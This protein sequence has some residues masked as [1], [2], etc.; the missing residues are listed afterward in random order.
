MGLVQ[1]VCAVYPIVNT[2]FNPLGKSAH[3]EQEHWFAAEVHPHEGQLKAYLHGTFPS[4]RDADDVVQESYL[5]LWKRQTIRPIGAA[6]AFLF[7]V[8]RHLALD[9]LR[10]ERR[11]PVAA[12][13]DLAA[14]FVIDDKPDSADNT[15][16]N[17]ETELLLA[18]IAAL[19][20]RTREVYML[21][22]F[23]GLS[24][25]QIAAHLGLSENTVEVQIGRANRRC[26]RFLRDRGV[27]R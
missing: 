12:V 26:E 8:A 21:R 16:V 15:C 14:L 9:L 17:E 5:R 23:E 18:A 1:T 7:A 11:N 4:I 2:S 24:Q 20:N 27:F 22:K 13:T 3:A 10:R 19:P 25:K 6:K